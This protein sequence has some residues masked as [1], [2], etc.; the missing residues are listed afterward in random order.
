MNKKLTGLL[1]ALS[2]FGFSASAVQA[3]IIDDFE[4]GSLSEYSASLNTVAETAIIGSGFAHDGNFGVGVGGDLQLDN[5]W[6]YRNDIVVSEGDTLSW[7]VNLG[8]TGRAYLGF[9]ADAGGTQSF[10]LASNTGDI[11][12]QDN[13]G[14][15]FDS[16][17]Q[18]AQTFT[19]DQW[20]FAEVIWGT[21]GSVI[22]NLY[23]SDGTTL[24]NSVSST[25]SYSTSGGIALRGFS[26]ASFD[27]IEVNRNSV[28]EPATLML[29]GLGLAGLGLSRKKKSA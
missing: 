21:A 28:P 20:Y 19:L 27:T 26:Q 25:V 6:I 23:G 7:W 4:D 11:R 13:A 16:L 9:G 18:S 5:G 22:G 3:T 17:D 8:N 1:A 12:F 2:L 14:W 10:V 15:G 29:M 24:L